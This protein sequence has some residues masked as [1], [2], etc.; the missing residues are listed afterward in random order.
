MGYFTAHG[1]DDEK[2]QIC[3]HIG[4]SDRHRTVDDYRKR[5]TKGESAFRD[6]FAVVGQNLEVFHVV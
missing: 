5:G 3:S 4:I 2:V 1:G 6:L